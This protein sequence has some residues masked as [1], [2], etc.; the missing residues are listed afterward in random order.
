MTQ[1]PSTFHPKRILLFNLLGLALVL[2]WQSPH[3]LAWQHLDDIVFFITNDWLHDANTLW[4][5]I[6]AATNHRVFDAVSFVALLLIFVWA[7]RRDPEF[8]HRLLRWGA[9]GITMLLT[10]G[11]LSQAVRYAIPY[12]HP[13]PTLVHE[14]VNLITQLVDFSTKDASSRSFPGDHGL[15]LMLFTAFL[16]RFAGRIV[17]LVSAAFAVLLSLP[18]ILGG[19]HW[20]SDI[21]MGALA[22]CLVV[23]PWVLC[24]PLAPAMARG[25]TSGLIAIKTGCYRLLSITRQRR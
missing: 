1:P 24:T 9:I 3:L 17:G 22:I 20:F 13:S 15:M 6:V 23:L 25:I 21:F 2:S 4:V 11:I 8:R 14:D 19:A 7:I 5:T 12:N 18:R 16:W 10:A